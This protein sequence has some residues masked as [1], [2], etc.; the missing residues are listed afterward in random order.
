MKI[1][2]MSFLIHI[3]VTFLVC[4]NMQAVA[5][6]IN[7]LPPQKKKKKL[8]RPKFSPPK[9]IFHVLE[10]VQI[11]QCQHENSIFFRAFLLFRTFVPPKIVSHSLPQNL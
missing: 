10:L 8:S 5:V 6:C 9:I 3:S 11:G 4:T 1:Q 7:P 2:T